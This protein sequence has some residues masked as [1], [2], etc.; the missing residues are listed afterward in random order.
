MRKIEY[1]RKLNMRATFDCQSI[2]SFNIHRGDKKKLVRLHAS[3]EFSDSFAQ[4][5]NN[6]PRDRPGLALDGQLKRQHEYNRGIA[7]REI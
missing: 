4:L 6:P 7:T 5:V 1:S 3:I 2:L